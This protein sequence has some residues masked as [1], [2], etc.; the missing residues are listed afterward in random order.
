MTK[1]SKNTNAPTPK[2]RI[3]MPSFFKDT[4]KPGAVDI[5]IGAGGMKP[6]PKPDEEPAKP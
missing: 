3:E 4:T 1:S 6:K 2:K 5:F